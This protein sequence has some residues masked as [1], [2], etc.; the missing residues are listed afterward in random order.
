MG[1]F[2]WLSRWRA[3]PDPPE[4]HHLVHQDPGD[5]PKLEEMRRDA[6][7]DVAELEKERWSYGRVSPDEDDGL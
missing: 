5:N 1:I 6:A 3:D 4:E 7:A 2:S